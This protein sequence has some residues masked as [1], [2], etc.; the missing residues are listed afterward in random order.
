MCDGTCCP[1]GRSIS[2]VFRPNTRIDAFRCGSCPGLVR[3]ETARDFD[4]ED[5]WEST[6]PKADADDSAAILWDLGA[7]GDHPFATAA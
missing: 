1:T 4:A 7:L 3:V 5:R 6:T 2:V